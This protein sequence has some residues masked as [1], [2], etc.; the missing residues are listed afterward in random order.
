MSMAIKGKRTLYKSLND[1]IT[2]GVHKNS[3]LGDIIKSDS[4]YV[5][6]M[7]NNTNHKIGKRLL[8]QIYELYPD[9]K[10]ELK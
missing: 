4:Q 3:T 1:I 10:N 8:K 2:F 9:L 7:H 6:W 5:I